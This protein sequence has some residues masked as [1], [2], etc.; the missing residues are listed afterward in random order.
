VRQATEMEVLPGAFM[1][2]FRI[3]PIARTA[4]RHPRGKHAATVLR[5]AIK[6][7]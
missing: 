6:T 2:T 3:G 1:T 4:A 5:S 7:P